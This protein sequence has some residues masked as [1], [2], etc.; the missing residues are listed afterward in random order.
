MI[1]KD[2]GKRVPFLNIQ[3]C[4][5]TLVSTNH[6]NLEA[7]ISTK[8]RGKLIK[9]MQSDFKIRMDLVEEEVT[10]KEYEQIE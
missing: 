9:R 3:I 4:R 5:L 1:E 8:F 2:I 6:T 7:K 10:W